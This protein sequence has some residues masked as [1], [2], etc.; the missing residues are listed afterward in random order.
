[1]YRRDFLKVS[2]LF[3]AALLVQTKSSL[4]KSVFEPVE[5][6]FKGQVLRSKR[7]DEIFVSRDSGKTWQLHTRLG[8]GYT[9]MDLFVDRAQRAHAQVVYAGRSFDLVLTAGNKYWVTA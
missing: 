7:D 8:A 1:M 4:L 3:S 6:A 9:V 2:A 5:V